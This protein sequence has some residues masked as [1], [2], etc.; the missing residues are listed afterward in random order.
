MSGSRTR[1]RIVFI[2]LKSKFTDCLVGRGGHELRRT[3]VRARGC[4]HPVRNAPEIS[5]PDLFR[6]D[7]PHF[8]L[9]REPTAGGC[10]LV[11]LNLLISFR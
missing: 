10:S 4:T 3:T 1:R 6:V 2:W 11:P 5:V 9:V 7:W 8:E